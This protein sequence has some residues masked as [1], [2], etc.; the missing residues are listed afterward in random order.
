MEEGEIVLFALHPTFGSP[1]FRY[2]MVTNGIAEVKL[3]SYGSFTVGASADKGV[4]QL[5]LDLAE[6]A[7]VSDHFKRH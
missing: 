3:V 6:L 1:P 2:A 7:N 4:T 5:E